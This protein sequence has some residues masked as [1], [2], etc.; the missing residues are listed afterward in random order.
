MAYL[1]FETKEEYLDNILSMIDKCDVCTLDDVLLLILKRLYPAHFG[2][3]YHS[4][5]YK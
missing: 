3:K 4:P 1:L 5:L 2:L